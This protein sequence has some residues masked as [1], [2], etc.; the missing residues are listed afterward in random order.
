MGKHNFFGFFKKNLKNFKMDEHDD[1]DK[2]T[3]DDP[4]LLNGSYPDDIVLEELSFDLAFSPTNDLVA[5]GNIDGLIDCYKYSDDENENV[6]S[7]QA[8]TKA[9]RAVNFS[10]DGNVLFSA[11]SDKAISVI[12]AKTNQI[13]RKQPNAHSSAIYSMSIKQQFVAT[14]DDDGIIKIWDM[15]QQSC[16]QTFEEHEDYVSQMIYI[17]DKSSQM[18]A[19]GGCGFLAVLDFRS[20]KLIARSD[21]MESELTC[22]ALI[23]NG[24]KC[25]VGTQEGTIEQWKSGDWG[26]IE[27]RST[28]IASSGIESMLKVDEERILTGGEDGLIRLLSI[29]PTQYIS[30]IAEHAECPIEAMQFSRDKKLLGSIGHDN[31]LRFANVAYLFNARA[32]QKPKPKQNP[33][34]KVS[35]RKFFSGL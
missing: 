12:D 35:N 33:S 7:L 15:R 16:V 29:E 5:V 11:S 3:I 13:I 6:F 9:V 27:T 30:A 8:H 31:Y 1:N 26:N 19:V 14:G 24:T 23:K 18:I 32:K 34:G 10:E 21:Q 4:S 22:C 2:M 25:V 20:G 17:P 28:S